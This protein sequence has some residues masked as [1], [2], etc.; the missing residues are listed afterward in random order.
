MYY[1]SA[2]LSAYYKVNLLNIKLSKKISRFVMI[3]EVEHS[4]GL[5]VIMSYELRTKNLTALYNS[6]LS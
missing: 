5:E 1:V 4:I 2:K 3:F 6:G